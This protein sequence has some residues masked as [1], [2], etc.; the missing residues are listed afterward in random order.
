M[1]ISYFDKA[2]VEKLRES[3]HLL[4]E[5][6]PYN[7]EGGLETLLEFLPDLFEDLPLD[8]AIIAKA[9]HLF[10]S[11]VKGHYFLGGN[12]RTGLLVSHA[13]LI[14]NGMLLRTWH[15]EGY[16]MGLRIYY[17]LIDAEELRA[18]I[19]NNIVKENQ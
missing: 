7:Y 14:C 12:K 18:W 4:R 6:I 16:L 2:L 1:D 9:A 8:D 15:G 5:E 19:K 11:M 10:I 3:L 13:F 17:D